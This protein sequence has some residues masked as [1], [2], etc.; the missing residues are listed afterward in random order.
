MGNNRTACMSACS[1]GRRK[2]QGGNA[3]SEHPPPPPLTRPS[4]GWRQSAR[5]SSSLARAQPRL[6]AAAR[7]SR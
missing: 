1:S 2:R 3:G 5:P 6:G 4:A 7:R